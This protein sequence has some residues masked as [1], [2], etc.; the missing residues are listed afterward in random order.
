MTRLDAQRKLHDYG[1]EGNWRFRGLL[2]AALSGSGVSRRDMA[3]AW[4]TQPSE[5]RFL[6]GNPNWSPDDA[7]KQKVSVYEDSDE[8][9]LLANHAEDAL[10]DGDFDG[11]YLAHKDSAIQHLLFAD[12]TVEELDTLFRAELADVIAEGAQRR[13][14]ARDAS[15]VFNAETNTG[16]LTVADDRQYSYDGAA[17]SGLGEGGI[18]PDDREGFSTVSWDCNKL[19]IGARVTDE[20]VRHARVDIIE[21]QITHVGE[22]LENDINRITL[23]NLVDN[24]NQDHDTQGSNLGVP[25]V[26]GG[27]TQVDQQDFQADT[28]VTHP[29]ARQEIFD[30]T[31]VVYANRSGDNGNALQNRELPPS[32]MGLDHNAASSNTYDSGTNTWGYTNDGEFGMV[33]YQQD[34]LWTVIEQDIEVKD[35][36]DPIR[37]LQGVNARAWVDSVLAQPDAASTV[38]R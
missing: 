19:G 26:N 28:L 7:A 36:D 13:Q 3:K 30:D 34:H 38:Q 17:D 1:T 12:S 37:D 18:I 15:F 2:L 21:R 23:N 8:Y 24:A 6:A 33:V 5:Y 20:M 4:P 35:Y 22:T 27:V 9:H 16:D 29:V 10:E 31:N 25:A 11:H 14:W 32:L